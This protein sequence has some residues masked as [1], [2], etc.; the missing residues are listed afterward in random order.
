MMVQYVMSFNIQ[1][2]DGE[3]NSQADICLKA[4]TRALD[5]GN[6]LDLRSEDPDS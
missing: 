2:V 4:I 5:S 3:N 1:C 6:C